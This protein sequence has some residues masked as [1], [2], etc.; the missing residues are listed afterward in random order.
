MFI[1]SNQFLTGTPDLQ[2]ETF[3]LEP[4]NTC[5]HSIYLLRDQSPQE[6]RKRG[7]I[8]TGFLSVMEKLGKFCQVFGPSSINAK[9]NQRAPLY[10]SG[11]GIWPRTLKSICW[12]QQC[13]SSLCLS[14]FISIPRQ[15]LHC[16]K[17]PVPGAPEM[18]SSELGGDATVKGAPD[19]KDVAWKSHLT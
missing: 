12:R 15:V 10:K 14:H 1:T 2:K 17:R 19:P 5:C 9:L 11:N 6:R 4:R 3:P 16:V 13:N 18:G 7:C 8:S